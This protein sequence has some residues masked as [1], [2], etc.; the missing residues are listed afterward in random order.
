MKR[1]K[2]L[3]P[4]QRFA[5]RLSK[6]KRKYAYNLD[7]DFDCL[8]S[9]GAGASR[10]VY[11]HPDF[12]FVVFKITKSA[13]NPSNKDEWDFYWNKA[14]KKQRKILAKPLYISENGRVLIM[15]RVRTTAKAKAEF[16]ETLYSL[17]VENRFDAILPE[18]RKWDFY[19]GHNIG[20]RGKQPVLFDYATAK[21]T[22]SP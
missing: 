1:R 22:W 16:N 14:N 17:D 10:T 12:P 19:V 4:Y 18:E 2:E 3:K 21:A 6:T 11:S 20:M 15:E 7:E 8:N 5:E 9:I 13:T